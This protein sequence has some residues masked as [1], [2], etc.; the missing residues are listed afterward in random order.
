M[1][2]P[3]NVRF[4]LH[5]STSHT[6]ASDPEDRG[7]CEYLKNP[8]RNQETLH[9][10]HLALQA[11]IAEGKEPPP[12]RYPRISDGTLVPAAEVRFPNI[13]GV[14]YTAQYNHKFV[15]D[16]STLPARHVPGTEYRVLVPQVDKDGN[17]IAG[18]GS[19]GLQTPT[20][21]YTGWNLRAAGFMA[22]SLCVIDGSSFPFAP[23]PA[24][25]GSGDPRPSLKE[26]YGS[27]AGYLEAFRKGAAARYEKLSSARGLRPVSR[28]SSEGGAGS[29]ALTRRP[30][31]AAFTNQAF[32]EARRAGQERL[33]ARGMAS[34]VAIATSGSTAPSRA[35]TF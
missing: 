23:T 7:M 21:T 5:P 18:I 28:Q 27:H 30:L 3:E 6:P 4:Y 10:L 22:G 12:S 13:P 9:A 19:A 14:R 35:A 8:N 29:A 31:V 17:D 20:A 1:P 24:E 32:D 16:Y 2:L 15:N 34:I 33:V 26:R 11:W 25:R